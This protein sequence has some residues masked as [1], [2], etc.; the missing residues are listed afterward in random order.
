MFVITTANIAYA[1]VASEGIAQMQPFMYNISL[2][3]Q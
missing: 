1:A 3:K 2:Q